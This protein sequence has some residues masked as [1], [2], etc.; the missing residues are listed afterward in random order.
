[1]LQSV[2]VGLLYFKGNS[3][4]VVAVVVGDY[5]SSSY[6]LWPNISQNGDSQTTE[7]NSS[8]YWRGSESPR[9]DVVR[10]GVF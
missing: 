4:V 2:V 5:E 9:S 7:T 6:S 3:F 8:Q 10:L 1:M